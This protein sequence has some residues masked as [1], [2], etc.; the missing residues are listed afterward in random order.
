M[1]LI[2]LMVKKLSERFMKKWQKKQTFSNKSQ[3]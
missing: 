2:I 3:K 1:L